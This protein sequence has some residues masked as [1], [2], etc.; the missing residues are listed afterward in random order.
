[1]LLITA[2]VTTTIAAALSSTIVTI[3]ALTIP[4]I[5]VLGRILLEL[6]ILFTDICQQIFAEFFGYLHLT[7]IRTAD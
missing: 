5:S 7:G 4:S 6:L 1:M 2:P 3:T